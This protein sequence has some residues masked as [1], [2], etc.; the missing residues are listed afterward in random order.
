[1]IFGHMYNEGF[2]VFLVLSRRQTLRV[3][4]T[5]IFRQNIFSSRTLRC[6]ENTTEIRELEAGP[7]GLRPED[8]KL[9]RLVNLRNN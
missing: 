6:C 7:R 3:R 8:I 1:M 9:V 4:K 2:W 5:L